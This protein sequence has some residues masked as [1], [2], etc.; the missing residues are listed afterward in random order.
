MS[1][2]ALGFVEEWISDHVAAEGDAPDN[3]K[4][5][6][7]AKAKAL[8]TQCL[9][10]AGAQGISAAEIGEAIDDL[11]EFMAGAIEEAYEREEHDEDDEDDEDDDED[12]DDDKDHDK[13][14]DAA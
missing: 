1:E 10:D 11:V 6:D 14:D 7:D 12:D 9:A 13:G 2:R 8:A 3:A 4:A 5:G